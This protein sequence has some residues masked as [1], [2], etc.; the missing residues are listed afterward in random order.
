MEVLEQE[1]EAQEKAVLDWLAEPVIVVA[2]AE[3]AELRPMAEPVRQ[4]RVEREVEVELVEGQPVAGPVTERSVIKEVTC[5]Q[6]QPQTVEQ[7]FRG[8]VEIIR[9]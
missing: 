2:V 9:D 8:R 4:L 7:M 6:L 5:V 3:A 1:V